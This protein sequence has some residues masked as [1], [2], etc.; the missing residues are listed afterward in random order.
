MPKKS[1]ARL[2][3]RLENLFQ[4]L[5]DTPPTTGVLTAARATAAS[6][7]S[8]GG[9]MWETD[10]EGRYVWCSPEVTRFLG[11]KP[12]D[13]FGRPFYDV[14][15]T[16]SAA[17]ALQRRMKAL[18]P[19]EDLRL[20]ARDAEGHPMQV[21]VHAMLRAA[22]SGD[23]LGYRGVVQVLTIAEPAKPR[24]TAHLEHRPE[25]VTATTPTPVVPTWGGLAGF[26]LEDGDLRPLDPAP[27]EVPQATTVAGDRL[28]VPLRLGAQSL[29]ILELEGPPGDA[30]DEEDRRMVEAVAQQLALALQDARSYQLTQQA[31]EEM[32]RADQLKSQFLAN[33]SHE[34]RTPL[35]SIIGFSR[36]ILK[37]IDGPITE[38]QEQDLK[39]IYNAGQHL[40]G[41]I[42]DILDLSKIEAGKMELAFTD[43]DLGEIIRGVMSTAVGLVKD[44]PIELI[45]DIPDDLPAIRADNIRVRQILLNL[46]SNAA[47]FTEEGQILVSARLMEREGKKEVL[48]AVSD[49]GPGID[50]KDQE[51]LFEPFS[52]VDASPTRKTGGTGLG[53]SI[54]RHLVELHGG[55]IW[56]ESTPG[57]GST[58]AFTLPLEPPGE[59]AP[60]GS[61]PDGSGSSDS[62]AEDGSHA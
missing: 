49:T 21:L 62:P 51:R 55:R 50:P 3:A 48:V 47:K 37:G 6:Q 25:E 58:F 13:L 12:E 19:L 41:L 46:V 61:A 57:E 28:I 54:T 59:T 56:M 36:V 11:E 30:W 53:L 7:R 9:W 8:P 23:I 52:Q 60:A 31:L 20:Q 24:F 40:L 32:R 38:T 45:T 10:P 39:A 17:Q 26:E 14:G 43:V 18:E 15:F 22:P 34:L 35:N 33:M 1:L 2:Q 44:K 5:T 16:E 29:G 42:N 4:T 27:V